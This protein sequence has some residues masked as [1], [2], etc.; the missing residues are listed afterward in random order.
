MLRSLLEPAGARLPVLKADRR[1]V[2]L[3]PGMLAGDADTFQQ[4]LADGHAARA[5]AL[6][7][8]DLLRGHFDEWVL[9]QRSRLA[10]KAEALAGRVV[11]AAFATP[12]ASCAGRAQLLDAVLQALRQDGGS[13]EADAAQRVADCLAGRRVLLVLDNF[14]QLVEAGRDD[15]ARWL[16]CLPLLRLLVTSRRVLGLDCEAEYLLAALP[17]PLPADSLAGHARNPSLAWFVDLARAARP[18][19]Q[20][21]EHNHLQVAVIVLALHG[22]PL[23]IELAAA[24]LRSLVVADLKAMLVPGEGAG[25]G[26]GLALLSRSGP[27]APEDAR[28]ASVLQ[29]LQWSWQ[30]LSAEE[31]APLAALACCDGGASLNLAALLSGLSLLQV[32]L[33]IDGLVSASVAFETHDAG[34]ASRY[35]VFGPLLLFGLSLLFV[36]GW[37]SWLLASE[38]DALNT[39]HANQQQTVDN[40]GKLRASLDTLAADTQRLANGGNASAALLVAELRKRGVTINPRPPAASAAAVPR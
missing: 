36:L 14:E 35:Q 13:C 19:F 6:Y 32:A 24:R 16:S 40:A 4:A 23:A 17:P 18:D 8:G 28:H 10:T 38:R 30:Q 20:L 12:P 7:L 21:N 33:R 31:Q 11:V 22:L 15:L 27:R 25:A 29:V 9:E 37:Q 34:A 1:T 2:R 26:P 5:A 39:A 3:A